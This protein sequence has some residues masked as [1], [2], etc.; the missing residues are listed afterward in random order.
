MRRPPQHRIDAFLAALGPISH[1]TEPR[2]V[3]AASRDF[4][5]FSPILKDR[6][7]RVRAQAVVRPGNRDE[8]LAVLAA[9][10]AHDIP[11]TPRGGGTGNYGQA[12]PLAGG[13]VLDL[14]GLD[15][16]EE[17]TPGMVICESGCLMGRL[18]D[19][20]AESGQELRMHPSTRETA[21]IGGFLSGGSGGVGS[22]RYGMLA[23]PGNVL[24]VELATC[25]ASPR[26]I[27]LSGAALGAALHAY[28]TTGV[29]ARITLPLAPKQAWCG[30]IATFD[31][32]GAAVRSGW[33][34]AHCDGMELKQLAAIQAPAPERW[35]GRHAVFIN[36][37]DNALVM[38]AA[39]GS[40]DAVCDWL[41]ARG[42]RIAFREDTAPPQPRP[43]PHLHHL[44]WNHTTLRALKAEPEITYLQLGTDPADPLASVDFIAERFPGEI[45]N[46]L[47]FVRSAGA[48]RI[49][50]LPLVRF[51]S[52][53]RLARI[54]ATVEDAGIPAWNPHAFTWEEGNRSDPDPELVAFKR[55]ADPKG[56]LNPGKLIGWE[57]PGYAYDMAGG[58]RFPWEEEDD[59]HGA[60]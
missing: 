33:A 41:T 27:P 45:V 21:T 12:M 42:A 29:I 51:S 13:V 3:A 6:L 28:G 22:L 49:S 16:V 30:I 40:R 44:C 32:W 24:A 26:L 35:F 43:L 37:G 1:R 55:Q 7:A 52:P 9:A 2:A 19:R 54:V 34:L 56:L 4:F 18:E 20:L 11:L 17:V 23:A 48:I 25:E 14:S 57:D 50:M 58:Y 15:R 60:D 36:P 5:W 53:E 39:P 10:Y 46:H 8:L 38:L 59:A 47:E 31:D